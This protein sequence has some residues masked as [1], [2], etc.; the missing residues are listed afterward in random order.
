MNMSKKD[1]KDSA[2]VG[3]SYS[4]LYSELPKNVFKNKHPVDRSGGSKG[5]KEFLK[6]ALPQSEQKEIDAEFKKTLS[7]A[8]GRKAKKL[9]TCGAP[10]RKVNLLTAKERRRL[11]LNRLPKRGLNFEDF[12]SMHDLWLD[13]IRKVVGNAGQKGDQGHRVEDESTVRTLG[14]EQLQMRISRADLHGAFIK[15]VRSTN[16]KMV[17]LEDGNEEVCA[18]SDSK[19][20]GLL[21]FQCGPPPL[22][23]RRVDHVHETKRQSRQEVEE[24]TTS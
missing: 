20:R 13:Y 24:Q 9:K 23:H 10:K 8:K 22:H 14:D 4:K 5:L 7:L 18:K 16:K 3:D 17:G 21:H 15:I 1:V 2:Q 6:A 19:K 11:G 12:H